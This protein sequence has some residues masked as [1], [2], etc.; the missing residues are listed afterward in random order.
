MYGSGMGGELALSSW[1]M[2]QKTLLE[3]TKAKKLSYVY[4]RT[5]AELHS[6][7]LQA[8]STT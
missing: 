8:Q 6:R 2:L 5:I 3:T 4:Q 7:P 1:S